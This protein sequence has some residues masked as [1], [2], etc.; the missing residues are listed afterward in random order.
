MRTCFLTAFALMVLVLSSS[1]QQ[2]PSTPTPK[3][4]DTEVWQPVPKV[5][6]PGA[7]CGAPPSDAIVL[8][9][10][11][12]EDEWVSV[13][14]KSPAQWIVADGVLT[15]NK[16]SG[17]IETRRSFKNYQLHLE[18][19]VPE[20]ITGSGQLRGN[21]G[22][23]LASTGPGD[24]GYELQILDSYN[25]ATYVNGMAASIYK[26]GIPLVNANRKP[27]EWQT[28]DV[29]WTAP[30]FNADGSVKTPA[31]VT[32][33]FNGVLVQNHFEL[34]GETLYIGQP[35]YKKY[36]RAPIKLQAHGDPSEPISFRN[37]WVRELN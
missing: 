11:K 36:D 28:Y 14:D 22:L 16:K 10:G 3:P 5:V 37:I 17:N 29:V 26:Q 18:W 21:S 31:Y 35:T 4:E 2:S 24:A 6:T 25:N 15:V 27:G 12:N 20:N 13:K 23:F 7:T 32:A 34:K 19:K 9:D 33:I 8:F 30:V 1:A